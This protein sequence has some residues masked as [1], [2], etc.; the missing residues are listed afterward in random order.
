MPTRGYAPDLIDIPL[1]RSASKYCR[2]L[3][4]GAIQTPVNICFLFLRKFNPSLCYNLFLSSP[5]LQLVTNTMQHYATGIHLLRFLRASY[6]LEYT[7]ATKLQRWERR[8][9]HSYIAKRQRWNLVLK[10]NNV[11]N[12]GN[13]E[14]RYNNRLWSNRLKG[15]CSGNPFF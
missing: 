4:V 5:S 13:P 15:N 10:M 1:I 6:E 12:K 9:K 3:P 11:L 2:Y 7:L 14:L 8:E